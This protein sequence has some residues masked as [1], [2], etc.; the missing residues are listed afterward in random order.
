MSINIGQV[1]FDTTD[2]RRLAAWWAEQTG[3][4]IVNDMEGFFVVVATPTG[5]NL[6][7]QK[8]ADPTPGKNKLHL[9]TGADDPAA[10]VERLVAAGAQL[11]AVHD[12]NPAFGWTVLADPDGNQFCVAGAH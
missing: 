2:P 7:F 11:V 10:E 3:G 12:E 6:G 5:L 4:Q 8:V 1:S 9:D